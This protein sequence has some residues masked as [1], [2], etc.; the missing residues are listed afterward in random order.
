MGSVVGREYPAKEFTIDAARVAAFSHALGI[1]P[2]EGV[3][4]TF[5][6]VYSLLATTPSLFADEDVA[7]DFAKLLH[8]EQDFQW[9]RH[10]EVGETVSSR[11]RITS[12]VARRGIRLVS[13]DVET[14]D[15]GGSPVCR[16][17]S[18]FVIRA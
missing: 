16:S 10:P 11:G 9:E 14:I 4:P 2:D 18:L 1:D 3:P 5:A 6:A 12:D 17:R 8:A 7:I 15:S 13:F